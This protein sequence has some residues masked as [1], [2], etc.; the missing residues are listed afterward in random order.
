[1]EE[2]YISNFCKIQEG[3]QSSTFMACSD[4]VAKWNVV[5]IQG[6]VLSAF[7][8]PIYLSSLLVSDDHFDYDTFVESFYGRVNKNLLKSYLKDNSFGYKLNCHKIGNYKP[9]SFEFDFD[10]SVS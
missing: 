1:M 2:T 4:K 10:L 6:A 3:E 8:Q 7:I 9:K 5:G